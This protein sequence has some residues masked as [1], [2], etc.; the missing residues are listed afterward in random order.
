MEFKKKKDNIVYL[1][2]S[3]ADKEA[4]LAF[5]EAS[6]RDFDTYAINISNFGTSLDNLEQMHHV[7]SGQ[8]KDDCFMKIS[9]YLFGQMG[10]AAKAWK[11]YGFEY[12]FP[13]NHYKL[14]ADKDTVYAL[15]E[16]FDA[17]FY[18]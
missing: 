8:L 14:E 2:A 1:Y 13:E 6:I 16:M 3:V 18:S 9:E 11:R 7:V 10:C 12:V 15:S 17:C 4:L 5:I